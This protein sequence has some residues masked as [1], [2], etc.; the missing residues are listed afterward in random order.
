MSVPVIDMAP[1]R[2]AG[3]SAS[4][5]AAVADAIR[6][7]CI[8][9]GF[10]YITGHGIQPQ[11]DALLRATAALFDLPEPDKAALAA[12]L[13][14]LHRG[15]TGVG[16][17]HNCSSAE[18]GAGPDNKESFLLG[19]EGAASPMHGPNPWP[20]A[21]LLPGWAADV[22]AY[23]ESAL[24]VSR[25]LARGLALALR[26]DE[27]FFADRMRDPVAQLLL[28]RYPPAPPAKRGGGR[29]VVGCGAHTDCGFLTVLA[30]DDVPGLEV[31]PRAAARAALAPG[32]AS[33]GG[34]GGGG[35]EGGWIAAPPRPGAL[36]INLGDL[37]EFWSGGLFRST[38]HRVTIPDGAA[39]GRPRHSVVFFCN[40]DFDAE[41]AP[42]QVALEEGDG[43]SAQAAAGGGGSGG[44]GAA[45]TAGRYIC[46]KLGLM[47]S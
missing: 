4:A 25:D 17:A 32:G 34:G 18:A 22:A 14:P 27:R 28:L 38:P 35:G 15:W 33:N 40:G 43:G 44:A 29:R 11:V 1:L 42:L 9:W 23:Y 5:K 24:A 19:A 21:A 26:L 13:S 16:G 39:A 47:Y 36:L 20:P 6:H 10:F 37:A 8:T 3:A 7:A 46:E 41:V 31:R 2:D 12:A 30:Q 45:T